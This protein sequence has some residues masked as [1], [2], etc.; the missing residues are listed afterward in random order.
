MYATLI[1]LDWQWT[2]SKMV[3]WKEPLTD[4]GKKNKHMQKNK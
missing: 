4:E 2:T 3:Q 1:I